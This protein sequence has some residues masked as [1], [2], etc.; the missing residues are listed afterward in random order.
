MGGHEGVKLLPSLCFENP[1][2]L[3][4]H[5]FYI[6]VQFLNITVKNFNIKEERAGKPMQYGLRSKKNS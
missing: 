1:I 3:L 6:G 2:G 5:L 4:F